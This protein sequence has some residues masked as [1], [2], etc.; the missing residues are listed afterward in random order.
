MRS[1][2]LKWGALIAALV[3]TASGEYALAR[4]AGFG[5]WLA[6]CVPA[7][8]DVYSLAAFKARRDIPA[9]VVALVLTNAAAHLHASGHLAASP[10]LVIAV[11]AIAPLVLWR[12]HSLSHPRKPVKAPQEPAEPF[13]SPWS[14]RPRKSPHRATQGRWP[15][16]SCRMP[17]HSLRRCSGIPGSRRR[18]AHFSRSCA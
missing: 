18:S 2:W 1:E 17:A 3:G 14:P 7:A 9:V 8:L 12:V 13:R 5:E 15:M 16:N 4:A 10:A 11:S 6:I